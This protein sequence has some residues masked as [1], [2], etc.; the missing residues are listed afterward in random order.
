MKNRILLYISNLT[1]GGA[2]RVVVN[3]AN[4]LV[5]RGHNVIVLTERLDEDEFILDKKV[6]RIILPNIFGSNRFLNIFNRIKNIRQVFQREKPDVVLSFAGKCNVRAL[7]AGLLLPIPIVPSVRSDPKR[8]YNGGLTSLFVRLLFLSA[9]ATVFQ[10]NQARDF[11]LHKTRRNSIVL[12]NPIN[13]HFMK[14]PFQG[15]KN[16]E[17]VSV[18]SLRKVKN[19]QMLV[20]AFGK[21]ADKYPD[22][23]LTIY[24][25]GDCRKS[26]EEMA[27][28]FNIA[29]RFFLPG[30]QK[31]IEE[32]IYKSR[33]FVLSSNTEGMPNALMEAMALGLA[34]ISTDCPCGGPATLIQHGENGMLVPVGDVECLAECLDII[35]GNQEL[36]TKLGSNASQIQNKYSSEKIL[37]EWE[38]FI[39]NLTK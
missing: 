24:G 5:H 32:K 36:E 26:L 6:K 7:F 39:D 22:T 34:V 9:S 11:F 38:G 35:L 1:C 14:T 28:Q 20:K 2:E 16:N 3:L 19:Q 13:E 21:I 37:K 27:K 4:F 29:E 12:M 31:E 25:E 33:I 10:T 30:I 8:E 18:G 15:K 23:I 17:I